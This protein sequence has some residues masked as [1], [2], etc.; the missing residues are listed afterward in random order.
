VAKFAVDAHFAD[1]SGDELVVLAAVVQDD[2]FIYHGS[3][4]PP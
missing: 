4:V 3:S 2:D 1:A